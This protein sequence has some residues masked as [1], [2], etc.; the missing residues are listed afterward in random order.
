MLYKSG[1]V[2]RFRA[3]RNDVN[4]LMFGEV[5]RTVVNN[6]TPNTESGETKI[7]KFSA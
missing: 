7:S 5:A 1:S 4:T 6:L 3:S 2:I